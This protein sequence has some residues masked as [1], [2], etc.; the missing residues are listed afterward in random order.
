MDN[1]EELEALIP[2]DKRDEVKTFVSGLVESE[3]TKGIDSYN[4]KDKEVLKYK[5]LVKE[6]GYDNEQFESVDAFKE[7]FKETKN[8]AEQSSITI[9][10]LNEKFE[11]LNT[12]YTGEVS[13]RQSKEKELNDTTIRSAL[14]KEIGSKVYGA[15]A[16]IEN[17][18]LKGSL[19]IIDNKIVDK[20]GNSFESFT[21]T[22][23]D[24]YKDDLKS[25]QKPGFDNKVKKNPIP[26]S[27]DTNLV[28]AARKRMKAFN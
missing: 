6:L 12:A 18:L 16:I 8:V 1:I 28:E 26:A 10:Q 13:K 14:D 5:T 21:T 27:K 20:D 15:N 23:L 3:K 9:E 7:S 2:E 25:E 24:Q 22:I 19:A 11:T 4:K 17:V